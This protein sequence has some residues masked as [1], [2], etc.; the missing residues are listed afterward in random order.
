MYDTKGKIRNV[1]AV[2]GSTKTE[3]DYELRSAGVNSSQ[4]G[5]LAPFHLAAIIIIPP[6]TAAPR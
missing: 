4:Q 5:V 3:V 2:Q 1:Q 6:Q